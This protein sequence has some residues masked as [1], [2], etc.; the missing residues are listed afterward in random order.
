[1][2]QNILTISKHSKMLMKLTISFNKS[3]NNNEMDISK[4][5]KIYNELPINIKMVSDDNNSN[6]KIKKLKTKEIDEIFTDI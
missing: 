5:S 6:K 2:V 4:Q 3:K 1:M